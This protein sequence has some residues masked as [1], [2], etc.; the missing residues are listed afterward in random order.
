MTQSQKILYIY[1]NAT[2][3]MSLSAQIASFFAC[4]GDIRQKH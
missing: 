1:E 3:V 4:V 2:L